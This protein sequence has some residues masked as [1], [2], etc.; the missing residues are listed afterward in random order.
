MFFLAK[1][2]NGRINSDVPQFYEATA[3]EAIEEGEALVLTSGKLTKCGATQTPQFIAMNALAANATERVIP[4][5]RVESVQLYRVP[6]DADPTALA[7]GAKV[8]IGDDATTVTSTTASGVATIVNLN[9][10]AAA[11]DEIYVRFE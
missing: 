11:D 7:V 5:L 2:E 4:V 10:A 3:N 1:C 9:G 6:V 8:T